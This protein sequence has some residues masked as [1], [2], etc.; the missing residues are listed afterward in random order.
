MRVAQGRAAFSRY[1]PLPCPFNLDR[2][3]DRFHAHAPA[4][5]I[6]RFAIIWEEW[7]CFYLK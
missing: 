2:F 6:T 5:G 4:M 3:L 7:S 1:D